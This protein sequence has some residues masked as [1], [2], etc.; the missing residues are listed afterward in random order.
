M[1]FFSKIGSVVTL[2]LQIALVVAAVLVFSFFDPFG[3]FKPS[4]PTLE[5]TPVSLKSIRSI[6]ELISAEYYGEVI[7]S[8]QGKYLEEIDTTATAFARKANTLNEA[9]IAAIA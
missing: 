2:L 7:V 5:D 6:G 8:L 4:A 1:V 3:M 9:F